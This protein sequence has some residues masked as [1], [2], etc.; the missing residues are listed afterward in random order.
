VYE[1]PW[2]SLFFQ[3]I[4]QQHIEDQQTDFMQGAMG[5]VKC[6]MGIAVSLVHPHLNISAELL[7]LREA[8]LTEALRETNTSDKMTKRWLEID[9]KFRDNIVKESL[10]DC[11]ERYPGSGFISF[12]KPNYDHNRFL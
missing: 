1:H 5:G 10:R 7:D 2:L 8:L 6:Y 4:D 11:S 3:K 9:E 12:N